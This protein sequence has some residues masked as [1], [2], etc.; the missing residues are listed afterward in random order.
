MIFKHTLI[1]FSGYAYISRR[2]LL[3][4]I[5]TTYIRFRRDRK[6]AKCTSVISI[7]LS[8]CLPVSARLQLGEFSSNLIYLDTQIYLLTATGLTPGEPFMEA[9]QHI[10]NLV[11]IGQK[12]RALYTKISV[13]FCCRRWHWCDINS[14]L[15]DWKLY[16]FV[17]AKAEETRTLRKHVTMLRHMHPA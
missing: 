11:K 12:Y 15:Y 14:A 13:K 17:S 6:D 4:A 3:H 5:A 16:W 8:V 2:N 1:L 10:R 7:C 9:F